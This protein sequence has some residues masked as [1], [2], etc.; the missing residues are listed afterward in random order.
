MVQQY[1]PNIPKVG[2]VVEITIGDRI[3][4]QT[5]VLTRC[6]P[7]TYS[8]ACLDAR[9][10]F[11]TSNQLICLWYHAEMDKWIAIINNG[12]NSTSNEEAT[13]EPV[14]PEI[15]IEIKPEN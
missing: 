11:I 1:P 4:F 10:G 8:I 6:K 13:V 12:D 3:P 5:T 7:G 2:D 14:K 9:L 15:G